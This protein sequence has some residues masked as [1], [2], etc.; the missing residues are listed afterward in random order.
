M[1]NRE[2]RELDSV[3]IPNSKAWSFSVEKASEIAIPFGLSFINADAVH[4][5]GPW[6]TEALVYRG[7]WFTE[8]TVDNSV[9]C[10]LFGQKVY[11]IANPGR[12]VDF[13]YHSVKS[14][15]S[16]L[17]FIESGPGEFKFEIFV[18][19]T[20]PR[21]LIVQPSLFTHVVLTISEPSLVCGFEAG[22]PSDKKRF[23]RLQTKFRN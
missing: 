11:M 9:S 8:T 5:T 7:L 3:D 1:T 14:M 18:I 10:T 21:N 16:F 6:F 17:S 23:Q 15:A 20:N 2:L 12:A 13:L 4:A 22:R 19:L